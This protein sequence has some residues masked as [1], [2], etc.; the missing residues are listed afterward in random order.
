MLFNGG[1]NGARGII[2]YDI[3]SHVLQIHPDLNKH[4]QLTTN[5]GQAQQVKVHFS[6]SVEMQSRK[7]INFLAF[8]QKPRAIVALTFL[9]CIFLSWCQYMLSLKL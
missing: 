8:W 1:Q 6:Y 4:A 3:W 5:Q 2:I 7:S 9:S